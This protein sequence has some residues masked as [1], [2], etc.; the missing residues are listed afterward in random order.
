MNFFGK[1][2]TPDEI[3]RQQNRELRR[4]QR[5]VDRSR[6]DIEKQEKQLEIQIKKAAKEGNKQLCTTLAKQLVQ[7][8]KSKTRTVAVGANIGAIGSQTKVIQANNKMAQAMATTTKTMSQMNAQLKPQQIMKTMQDFEKENQMMS[9][10]EEMI[11]DTLNGILD[12]S[13]D[14][15]EQDAVVA[16]VLDEIGIEITGKLANA[17]TPSRDLASTSKV[18][19]SEIE[20]QLAKLKM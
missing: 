19:D 18:S 16:K 10:K 8:R 17:P 1:K 5:D 14:E 6:T 9:M 13:G 12:E 3:I 7:L 11:E 20:A 2:Q 4:A 15:E